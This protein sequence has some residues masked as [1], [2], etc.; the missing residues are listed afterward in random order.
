MKGQDNLYSGRKDL[1]CLYPLVRTVS[2]SSTFSKHGL[3]SVGVRLQQAY[4]YLGLFMFLA[5]PYVTVP[6]SNM[7]CRIKR[8]LHHNAIQ[9]FS[10][11]FLSF[12]IVQVVKTNR[13][14]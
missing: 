7:E 10:I 3:Y 12:G 9:C 1:L 11:D 2:F 5:N 13:A 8:S 14:F 4:L 6:G